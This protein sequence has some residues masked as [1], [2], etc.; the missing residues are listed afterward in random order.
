MIQRKRVFFGVLIA[1]ALLAGMCLSSLTGAE[2]APRPK[3]T[4]T[5]TP[6]TMP[7]LPPGTYYVSESGNDANPGTLALPWQHIQSALDR[8][9]AGS[10]VYVLNGVYNEYVTFQG[11]GSASGGYITLQNYPGHTPVIDAAGLPISG[12]VGVIN[13]VNRQY[14]T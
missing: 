11:S 4:P 7:S 10:T 5:F 3:A 14:A 8:V 6:T 12:E 13:I 9:G 1:G 2:A